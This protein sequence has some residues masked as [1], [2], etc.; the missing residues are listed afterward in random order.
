MTDPGDAG[1]NTLRGRIAAA[2]PAGG[3]IIIFAPGISRITLT[4]G[5]LMIDRP[6]TIAGPGSGA[7]TVARAPFSPAIGPNFGVFVVKGGVSAAVSGL[8]VTNGFAPRGGGITNNGTLTLAQV[9]VAGNSALGS[10]G[11]PDIDPKGGAGIYNTGTLTLA[12]CTLSGNGLISSSGGAAIFNSGSLT[13][14]DST[15]SGN[16]NGS[17]TI[18]NWKGTLTLLRSTV[19]DD[20]AGG[21]ISNLYGTVEVNQSTISDNRGDGIGS[22]GTLMVNRSTISGNQYGGGIWGGGGTLTVSSSTVASN[23]GGGIINYGS[24]TVTTVSNSTIAGNTGTYLGM[25]GG[26][27][28]SVTLSDTIVAGNTGVGGYRQRFTLAYDVDG[29]VAPNSHNNLIGALGYGGGISNGTNGNLAGTSAQPLGA[30]LGPLANNGSPLQTMALLRGSPAIDAGSN[31]GA[32]PTDERGFPRIV[33]GTIDIGAYE[34]QSRW[35][36][37]VGAFDPS[38]ATWYLHD[39]GAAAPNSSPFAYGAPGWVPVAGDWTGKGQQTIG[40]VN[41]TPL[42]TQT[43]SLGLLQ[44]FPLSALTLVQDATEPLWYLRNSN[45]PGAPD[46]GPFP[47]GYSAWI[48]VVGDWS[49]TGHTGIGMYDPSTAT[50]YLRNEDSPG[51]PDAGVFQFGAPGWLPV[52]GDWDGDGKTTVGVIDPNTMTWY[53]RNRNTP[54]APDAGAFQY[55][56]PGWKPV[57]GDW[58]GDGKTTIG[59]VD[60][61]GAWYLRD[62]NSAG[63]PDYAPSRYGLAGWTP[64]AGDWGFATLTLRA[65]GGARTASPDLSSLT[66]ADL[67]AVVKAALG[68]LS[69]AGVSPA[70]VSQ[71]STAQFQVAGLG[72]DYLGLAYPAA[73]RVVISADAAG[74]GWFVDA[75]P[76]R[77][78]EFAVGTPG[79]PLTALPGTAAGRM[80]LLT[81]V[82]HEMGH[83]AGRPDVS[84]AGHGDD[85]MADTLAPGVRRTE[86]LDQVFAGGL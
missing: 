27:S 21:G 51:P 85:L 45:G 2:N 9:V 22:Y 23:T 40:A 24:A 11:S 72:G 30:K 46:I 78:A 49:G 35:A 80:D 55:G 82:L 34:A 8:T 32:P 66:Q 71:L 43:V 26:I 42:S 50:W 15:I 36:S 63:A 4:S 38:T 58:N 60:P 1:P 47:Y 3:D 28:G 57:V 48:P 83:L 20:P 10:T 18:Y 53:L 5:S 73:N 69:A 52:T 76:L 77:D 16:G 68:R 33:N 54:G 81:A 17:A 56:A 39:G 86:A 31:A 64:L 7:L 44:F 12:A 70:L 61:A 79:S 59:V 65:A 75:S 19:S 84:T 25:A 62:Q 41:L 14:S 67:D 37:A 6:L 13:A 74:Y 29:V